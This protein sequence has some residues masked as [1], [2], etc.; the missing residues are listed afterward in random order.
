MQKDD[1]DIFSDQL[2]EIVLSCNK[3]SMEH[4]RQGNYQASLHLLRRAQDILNCPQSS[5][6]KSK[7]EAITYNNLGCYYKKIGKLSLALQFLTKALDLESTSVIDKSNLAGTHLNICT[8]R[9]SL[10]QH[11]YAVK[12]AIK[13]IEL[14]LEAEKTEHTSNLVSTLA[15]AYHN[16]GVEYEVLGEYG[17]ARDCYMNGLERAQ[18]SLGNDHGI[19][20]TLLKCYL[21]II[22]TIENS[23]KLIR[24]YKFE[25]INSSENSKNFHKRSVSN[26]SR[27]SL[28]SERGLPMINK[29]QKSKK[30]IHSRNNSFQI[31]P[32]STSSTSRGKFLTNESHQRS[33]VLNG[34]QDNKRPSSRMVMN[35]QTP[36]G[37]AKI[38]APPS[39][40]PPSNLRKVHYRQLSRGEDH[41]LNF[42]DKL[43]RLE[44]QLRSIESKYDEL[45]KV[46]EET[47]YD[48]KIEK[49]EDEEQ[50][51]G[52]MNEKFNRMDEK[53]I[54]KHKALHMVNE[55]LFQED[56][57]ITMKPEI[58]ELNL[59]DMKKI[60]KIDEELIKEIK[61]PDIMNKN[62]DSVKGDQG[63]MQ[64]LPR[65]PLLND[66]ITI[67]NQLKTQNLLRNSLVNDEITLKNQERLYNSSKN[68]YRKDEIL[69]S[70]L[71]KGKLSTANKN[72]SSKDDKVILN[73]VKSPNPPVKSIGN[74]NPEKSA[75]I[76]QHF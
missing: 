57:E 1:R 48:Q 8:I 32:R 69:N 59:T 62:V 49:Y 54:A 71:N 10:N 41:A 33:R 50:L 42:E 58:K 53:V 46:K 56:H 12:N 51:V 74:P 20:V 25:R 21:N 22:E 5:T 26:M 31:S 18:V 35:I 66:E 61:K 72:F 60:K 45:Y 15:I 19:T 29:L 36:A 39:G 6:A 64:N 75:I 68:S 2:Q 37:I 7:L 3:L 23:P 47:R 16:A 44:N 28:S 76:I 40:R 34:D 30:R 55:R 13:A 65:N 11:D 27:G 63:L 52:K 24:K 43:A 4:L 38:P 73:L 67:K 14:L 17:I 9:S 70:S